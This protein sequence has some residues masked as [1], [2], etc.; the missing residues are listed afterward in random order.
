[1]P[2]PARAD[3]DR[4]WCLALA[5]PT[6]AG[7][8]AAAL[9]LARDLPL[10]IVSVDSAL[11]YRGMDIG[12]AKPSAHERA[13][14]P[15]HLIDIVD[16]AQSYSAARFAQDADT[17]VRAINGRGRMALLA[18]G[19][20][21]YFKAL[22]KG[23]ADLP[24]AEPALRAR[25]EQERQ[26]QGLPAL[27][28]RLQQLDPAAAERISANDPQRILRALEVIELTGKPMTELW[29]HQAAE[30]QPYRYV[31]VALLPD[32]AWLHR[33]IAMRLDAM[34][35]AG[36]VEEVKALKARNDLHADLPSIRCVGYR[37]IWDFLDGACNEQE[38]RERA[39]AATRQLAKR[40]YTWLR[41]WPLDLVLDENSENPVDQILKAM[42]PAPI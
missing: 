25:L 42:E 4:P 41:K 12:T 33:R 5:G 21:L 8:T 36:F 13:L 39:L 24:D 23:I 35:A 20:M 2:S 38:M 28:A 3:D 11:V 9:A 1:M 17:L 15:H 31:Q 14:V 34:L 16:P 22:I 40:Q 32:R 19:T 37:Q 10:E 30:T 7:K 18:G 29:A 6:A 27:Y 26:Q